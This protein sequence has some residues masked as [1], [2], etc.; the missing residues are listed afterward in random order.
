MVR[1]CMLTDDQ[2]IIGF[3]VEGHAKFTRRSK[4]D[5]V[6][7]AVSALAQATLLGLVERLKLN[8]GYEMKNGYMYC[9]IDS[10]VTGIE[11]ESAS[12]LFD[13]LLLGLKATEEEYGRYL[14]TTQREV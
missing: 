5:I 3:E 14:R 7:S 8:V 11:R 9:I 13:T 12:I 2:G 6:C 1:A 10:N 4:P